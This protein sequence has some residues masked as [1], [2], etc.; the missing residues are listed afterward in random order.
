MP[1]NLTPIE[2]TQTVMPSTPGWVNILAGGV[3]GVIAAYD[4]VNQLYWMQGNPSGGLTGNIIVDANG[5]VSSSNILS[6]KG[7]PF[8]LQ[9]PGSML[10]KMI[11]ATNTTNGAIIGYGLI[12]FL[13]ATGASQ[14]TAQTGGHAFH[15]TL[16]TGNLTGP[17][18]IAASFDTSGR[19]LVANNGTLSTDSNGG[20]LNTI[21]YFGNTA[22][23][24]PVGG[25]IQSAV[26]WN[27]RLPDATL[28]TLSTP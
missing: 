9:T 12:A 18:S 8:Q 7:A 26:F 23:S 28:Q 27:I 6:A 22:G 2:R 14:I 25:H 19:S 24:R 1:S 4:F 10:V 17:T 13:S 16:G 20:S 21:N 15:T 5:L 3:P 11:G